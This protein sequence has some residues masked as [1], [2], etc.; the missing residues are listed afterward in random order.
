MRR[1]SDDSSDAALESALRVGRFAGAALVVTEPEPLPADHP[2]LT[3]ANLLVVPHIGSATH[4][5][6]EALA[7][8]SG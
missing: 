4:R 7:A 6:R 5:T 8:I 2:L 3:A 1:R